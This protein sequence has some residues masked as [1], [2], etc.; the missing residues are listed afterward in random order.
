MANGFVDLGIKQAVAEIAAGRMR[1]SDVARICVEQV[2]AWEGAVDAWVAFDAERLM[3]KAE[4]VDGKPPAGSLHGMPIGVKDIFNTRDFPT[5]MGSPIWKGFTPG[6]DA[7]SVFHLLREGAIVPGKTTTAEFAVHAL[8]ATRNPYDATR[9][10]GTSSSGSAVSVAVGMVPASLGTQ[11]AGSIVRPASFCGI[12]GFKPSFGLIPRTGMLK[13]TDSLDTIGYFVSHA[14]DISVMLDALRVR[15]ADYPIVDSAFGDTTGGLPPHKGNWRVGIA[16]GA[17]LDHAE[18]YAKDALAAWVDKLSATPGIEVVDADWSREVDAAHDIH[19][20]IYDTSLAYYFKEE[21]AH[22][23]LVSPIMNELIA[24]GREVGIEAYRSALYEQEELIKKID[25][26]FD[27]V[28]FVVTLSTAGVAPPREEVERPDSALIWTLLHLPALSAPVFQDAS[29][30]PFGLQIV[31]R[32]YSD[33]RMMQFV[34]DLVAKGLLPA[35][36]RFPAS[37]AQVAVSA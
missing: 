29:G 33:Q 23:E 36:S 3:V 8:S 18:G 32:R 22:G 5:E 6:N 2:G 21:S 31:G 19:A 37:V 24:R 17:Y 20:T 30:L 34:D 11:T 9:T 4:A 35:K 1:V 7:R 14:E 15:G 27:E 10:P 25:R 26:R 28:D 12:Y 16:K 13:T